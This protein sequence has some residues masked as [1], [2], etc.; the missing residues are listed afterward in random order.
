MRV[1][2]QLTP[3]VTDHCR[4]LMKVYVNHFSLFAQGHAFKAVFGNLVGEPFVFS[5]IMAS[6]DK[7]VMKKEIEI[8]R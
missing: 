1:I 6:I 2:A 8:S 5:F 4:K 7:L 3:S